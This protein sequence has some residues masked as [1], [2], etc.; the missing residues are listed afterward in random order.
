MPS[1]TDVLSRFKN[2]TFAATVIPAQK[3]G[4]IADAAGVTDGDWVP[5]VPAS[6]AS[7]ANADIYVLVDASVASAMP[8]PGFAANS[9]AKVAANAIRGGLTDSKVF[10]PRYA[11]TCWSLIAA[12]DGVKVGATYKAGETELEAMD[13]FISQTGEDAALRKATYE[14]SESWYSSITTNIFG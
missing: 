12:H 1:T 7:Q 5:I 4:A 2:G 11:N 14:E 3:A 13:N 8:K 10:D 9:Q 6:M